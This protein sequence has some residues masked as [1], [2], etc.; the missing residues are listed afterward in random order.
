MKRLGPTVA[1]LLLAAPLVAEDAPKRSAAFETYC[2]VCHGEDGKANT[3]EGKKKGARDLTNAKWQA[4]VSDSR[5][6]GSITRGRDK[7]PAFGRKLTAE[8][9]KALVAEV[10]SLAQSH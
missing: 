2:I 6:E 5:L 3:E 9:I 7:M 4:T 1:A 8:Q 10:R